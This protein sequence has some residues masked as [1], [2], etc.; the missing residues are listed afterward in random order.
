MSVGDSDGTIDGTDGTK[1]GSEGITE[2]SIEEMLLDHTVEFKD[3]TKVIITFPVD[4]YN[5]LPSPV[6]H[7]LFTLSMHAT[8]ALFPHMG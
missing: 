4:T 1:N 2:G 7:M 6:P 3:R 8:A 5:V